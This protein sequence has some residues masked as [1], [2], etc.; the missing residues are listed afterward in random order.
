MPQ[1]PYGNYKIQLESSGRFVSASSARTDLIA[2]ASSADAAIFN[3]AYIP[4]AGTLQLRS[5][6]MYVTADGGGAS[7]LSAAR[8]VASTWERFTIRQKNGAAN[9]VYTIKAASN[10]LWVTVGG[11]GSLKNNGQSEAASAGFRFVAA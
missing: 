3:S 2:S 9:G 10:G 5:T 6:N 11:D 7:T 1:N 4:N 8:Q